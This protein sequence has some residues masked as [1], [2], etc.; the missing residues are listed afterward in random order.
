MLT[1]RLTLLVSLLA[2]CGGG[3]QPQP[4]EPK[5]GNPIV[6]T[7]EGVAA[8][9]EVR[10]N[11]EQAFLA[12]DLYRRAFDL[13]AAAVYPELSDEYRI[14]LARFRPLFEDPSGRLLLDESARLQFFVVLESGE[15]ILRAAAL[16]RMALVFVEKAQSPALRSLPAARPG[17]ASA[18]REQL[19]YA[20]YRRLAYS[21][22]RSFDQL[23][24]GEALA[25]P[26]LLV[27]ADA[28]GRLVE[29][30]SIKPELREVMARARRGVIED[31]A[32]LPPL[33]VEL[34]AE[35]LLG[36]AIE[37]KDR[38]VIQSAPGGS[39][40]TAFASYLQS[41]ACFVLAAEIG[42]AEVRA[43]SE[44][45]SVPLILNELELMIHKGE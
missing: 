9:K 38:A 20:A 4:V 2:G 10:T 14:R 5:P 33:R 43:L 44:F 18:L 15:K 3:A 36:Q 30:N 17:S 11:L 12:A 13:R 26:M 1:K 22:A 41:L 8:L 31:P 24:E 21:F 7:L 25:P 23:A 29:F 45:E 34:P 16:K 32:N 27:Y 37:F 6:T 19:L 35:R 28:L 42:S 40:E 39:V